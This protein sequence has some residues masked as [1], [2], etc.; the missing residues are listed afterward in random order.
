MRRFGAW[1]R[2]GAALTC[3]IVG[4]LRAHRHAFPDSVEDLVRP[5]RDVYVAIARRAE[6]LR[7]LVS[8]QATVG[9]VS[10]ASAEGSDTA[11][12]DPAVIHF[13][14]MQY[15]LA[16]TLVV[17]GKAAPLVVGDFLW[18]TP[19]SSALAKEGLER[20]RDVG[21]GVFLLRRR[22]VP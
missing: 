20:V 16:P 2:V 7:S 4:A 19:D 5:P 11:S 10:D 3:A 1:A 21:D 15:A 6:P 18:R 13:R 22:P 12:N 17:E 9:Y 14:L 8:S